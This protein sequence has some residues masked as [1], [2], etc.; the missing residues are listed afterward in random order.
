[1]KVVAIIQARAGSTRLPGKIFKS[2][3]GRPMLVHMLERVQK[4]K[5][6]DAVVLATGD[7][8][9]DDATA[10]L[11]ASCGVVVFR[12]SE[13]DVLD[14]FYKAAQEAGADVV[15]RLTGDCVLHDPHVI[16]E[17]V[18]RF[19]EKKVDYTS[20]P[21]NYPEGLDTE[22]FSFAAL[23]RAWREAA[24]PS[25][26]EHVTPYI[27]NHPELFKIDG[28]W[29]S[30]IGDN[31]GMH[32][33]VDMQAD[34]DFA[35]AVYAQLYPR[36]ASFNKD[37]VLALLKQKPELLEINKGGTGFEGLRKSLKEDEGWKL[38]R[39]M[40]LGTVELGM[41]YGIDGQARPA[42]DEAF[43][44][45][46]AALA[47]GIDT[48]DTASAYGNAEELLGEWITARNCADKVKIISKGSGRADIEQSLKRLGLKALDGY[49]LHNAQ[50]SFAELQEAK[51][52]GLVKHVGAS[53][54]QPEEVRGEFEYVQVPY[55]ALDRRFEKVQDAVVFA[56]SPFLQG[57]LLMNPADVPPHLLHARPYVEAFQ[58]IAQQFGLSPLQA[59]LLFALHAHPT[60]VVVFGVKTLPQLH[61]IIAAARTLLPNGYL[62]AVRALPV[63]PDTVVNPTLWKA[64]VV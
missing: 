29:T 3:L 19:L 8:H 9:A 51:R 22:V 37:D 12:G 39:R 48:F 52:A 16:D 18:E 53:V 27:K 10:A 64:T 32:W 2:M 26:R 21:A 38:M 46:D 63:P 50:G 60:N 6:L 17:V 44:I 57:L 55:N 33:S 41:E 58:K 5:K 49:L 35:T 40:V 30:G 45:L 42:K 56:R 43:A 15:V 31:S 7:A 47:A 36:N 54:Y 23:E 20:T 11:G 62:D 59:A 61:E 25:E 14:R 4:A 1:M 34:F 13:A 28:R 24:I